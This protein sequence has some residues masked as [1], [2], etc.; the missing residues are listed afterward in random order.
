MTQEKRPVG[1]PRIFKCPEDF[2]A[3][4]D[5]YVSMCQANNEPILLMGMV[6]A[7][8]FVSKD[9]FYEY[10]KYPEFS[11]SVKRARA[12]VEIE[13]EKRLAKGEQN[14]AGPIF[15]LKNF[16]WKDKVEQEITNPDGS[17]RPTTIQIVPPEK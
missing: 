5:N 9:S 15:A 17:L 4:V 10:Q 7:L 16:G 2:D 1:R 13:Y 11:D 8:G 6:L 14:A 3:L 12:L